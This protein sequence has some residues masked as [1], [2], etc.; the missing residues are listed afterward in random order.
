[1]SHAT[2]WDI[3]TWRT[4]C[5]FYIH[6]LTLLY[7]TPVSLHVNKSRLDNSLN[8]WSLHDTLSSWHVHVTPSHACRDTFTN[9]TWLI[10]M[11]DMT[12]SY[13]WRDSHGSFMCVTWLIR[14][15]AMT[16]SHVW[17]DSCTY[18]TWLI[19]IPAENEC[20]ICKR[21]IE[22]VAST[23]VMSHTHDLFHVHD[24]LSWS[25]MGMSQ[26]VNEL[27]D[28]L[29]S[30]WLIAFVACRCRI[31]FVT[32]D[33]LTHSHV[34]RD[35]FTYQPHQRRALSV[36]AHFLTLSSSLAR[37][38]ALIAACCSALQC[39]AVYCSVLQ[40]F[41]VYCSVLQRVA[42][43][44]SVLQCIAA[45]CSALQCIAVYCSVLQRTTHAHPSHSSAA[46][47]A[48]R[49]SFTRGCAYVC[50]MTRSCVPVNACMIRLVHVWLWTCVTSHVWHH[51]C[52]I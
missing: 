27:S 1:M 15:R 5:V 42:V 25:G 13:M 36:T 39:I 7:R 17:H 49:C 16:H 33:S 43:L 52:D 4:Y 51:M 3:Y 32:S 21:L 28:V 34:C 2:Q 9:V 50:D 44:C 23:W 46:H 29:S 48:W 38:C 26:R 22:L 37:A 14:M 8:W 20:Q 35:S 47:E 41:A 19:H 45:C 18:L 12:Q 30:W 40:C 31:E 11:C 24:L 10:Y 6:E